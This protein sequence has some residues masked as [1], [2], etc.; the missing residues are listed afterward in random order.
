MASKIPKYRYTGIF[1]IIHIGKP[2]FEKIAVYPV[3]IFSLL[4]DSVIY[5]THNDRDIYV[6]YLKFSDS[7]LNISKYLKNKSKLSGPIIRT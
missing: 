5:A 2:V 4:G 1:E 6:S 7:E 3:Y